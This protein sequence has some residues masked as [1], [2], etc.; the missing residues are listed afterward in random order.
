M[1]LWRR[2]TAAQ[3]A[4][5]RYRI[6]HAYKGISLCPFGRKGAA[7]FF[8]SSRRGMQSLGREPDGAATPHSTRVIE[9][10]WL[11]N[12]GHG[13]SLRH[14]KVTS[15]ASVGAIPSFRA[16]R[17]RPQ[18]P[19]VHQRREARVLGP[20]LWT[21]TGTDY[22]SKRGVQMGVPANPMLSSV[23]SYRPASFRNH[24]KS[25]RNQGLVFIY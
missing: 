21:Q 3:S 12:G 15:L 10:P 11:V 16:T 23:S 4:G 14:H 20:L 22:G 7:V 17:R 9:A 13:A 8:V 19:I 2:F 5:R 6:A 25:L 1:A 24:Y 18:Q